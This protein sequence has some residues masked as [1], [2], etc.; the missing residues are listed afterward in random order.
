VHTRGTPPRLFRV[1][2]DTHGAIQYG[3]KPGVIAEDY[4]ERAL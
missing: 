3:F 4:E 1:I 2:D